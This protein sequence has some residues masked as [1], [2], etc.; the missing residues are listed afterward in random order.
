MRM[1]RWGYGGGGSGLGLLTSTC[2]SVLNYFVIKDRFPCTGDVLILEILEAN[3]WV[4]VHL[5]KVLDFQVHFQYMFST[6]VKK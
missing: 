2:T 4:L 6:S 1:N 5:G 3:Y